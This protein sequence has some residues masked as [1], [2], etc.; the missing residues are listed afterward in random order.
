MVYIPTTKAKRIFT[1]TSIIEAMSTNQPTN[2]Q[3]NPMVFNRKKS[4]YIKLDLQKE[5]RNAIKK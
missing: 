5:C 3:K 2:K 4:P 1:S